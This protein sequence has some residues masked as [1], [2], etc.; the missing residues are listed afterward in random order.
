VSESPDSELALA[1]A[2][3]QREAFAAIYDRYA[4]RIYGL[5]LRQLRNPDAAADVTQE[6]FLIAAQRLAGLADPSRLRSWLFAVARNQLIDHVRRNRRY[7]SDEG[8]EMATEDTTASTVLSRVRSAELADLMI[9][10]QAGLDDRDRLVLDLAYREELA[11]TELADALGVRPDHVHQLLSRARRRLEISL[12]A[13]LVAR[14]GREDCEQLADLLQGWDGRFSTLW[15]KRVARHVE[16][17]A[18][19]TRLRGVVLSPASLAMAMPLA[20]APPELRDQALA[21]FDE[22]IEAGHA[23]G[24]ASTGAWRPDGFPGRVRS[25]RL[26]V[27]S[28]FAGLVMLVVGGAVLAMTTLIGTT[29][30]P[31]AAVGPASPDTAGLRQVTPTPLMSRTSASLP[32]S[33][34]ASQSPT[35]TSTTSTSSTSTT[36]TTT[37]STSESTPGA[38]AGG[39]LVAS[40]AAVTI[41]P[42]VGSRATFQLSHTGSAS[43]DFIVAA[44]VGLSATPTS[45]TLGPGAS[46][47]I[48]LTRV[49]TPTRPTSGVV[50][51]SSATAEAVEVTVQVVAPPASLTASELS[52]PLGVPRPTSAT[53][54]LSNTGGAAAD[55]AARASQPWLG[56]TPD[57]GTLEPEQT[58][59]I[60]VSIT[61]PPADRS[62]LTPAQFVTIGSSALAPVIVQVPILAPS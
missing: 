24:V 28:I 52:N 20:A 18:V 30:G 6:T 19:C 57:V 31:T 16:D 51:V 35:L 39:S 45:G 56:V 32:S 15:R 23:E 22:W 27:G 49:G 3:G 58:T 17:C 43:M 5:C 34:A 8:V 37:D 11:G 14:Q 1:A 44:S 2:A 36:P 33:S 9:G 50:T 21:G 48:V 40:P 42:A 61:G 53:F 54:R 4:D 41:T 12:G 46:V 38:P 10:A 26:L 29:G 62:Q 55:W 47:P 7:V 60:T 59:T 25:R 13:L